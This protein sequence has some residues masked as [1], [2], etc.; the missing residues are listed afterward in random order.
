MTDFN[1]IFVSKNSSFVPNDA[2]AAAAE[3]LLAKLY[4][5]CISVSYRKHAAPQFITSGDDFDRFCCPICKTSVNSH[6]LSDEGIVWWY[7]VFLSAREESQLIK[8]P[9]CGS[10][11]AMKDFDFGRYAAF[12]SFELTVEGTQYDE[13][14]S[15]SQKNQLE[16]VLG[17]SVRSIV[18]VMT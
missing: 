9:C 10:E 6:S 2:A 17:C 15:A 5:D 7:T 16:M 14:L 4:P 3:S 1:T 8:V 13:E 18:V 11:V 12:G